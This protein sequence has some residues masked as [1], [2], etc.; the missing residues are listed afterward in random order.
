MELEEYRVDYSANV[1]FIVWCNDEVCDFNEENYLI[2]REKGIE[3]HKETGHE[4]SGEEGRAY[5]IGKKGQQFNKDL[6]ERRL[7]ALG[8]PLED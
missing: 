7:K 5:W 1:H 3:H 2:S 8:I 4:V 6:A